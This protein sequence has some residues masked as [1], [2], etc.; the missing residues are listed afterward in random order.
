MITPSPNVSY[1]QCSEN[2]E[3]ILNKIYKSK[4]PLEL[5][6]FKNQ[7]AYGYKAIPKLSFELTSTRKETRLNA[8]TFLTKILHKPENAAQGLTYNLVDILLLIIKDD[9]V[10]EKQLALNCLLILTS[11]FIGSHT[12]ATEKNFFVLKEELKCGDA[13]IRKYIYEIF[14]GIC[15]KDKDGV[16]LF[17]SMN[18]YSLFMDKLKKECYEFQYS[19][20]N[21]LYF[22][23]Q[24]GRPSFIPTY[25]FENLSLQ[26]FSKFLDP[27]IPAK[28]KIIAEKCIMALCL[29]NEAKVESCK[30]KI[31]QKLVKLLKNR[32]KEVR[33]NAVGA[34][35]NISI[36]NDAKK[37][38]NSTNVLST[39]LD[40][41]KE[42]DQETILYTLKTITNL[43]EDYVA[44]DQL[45]DKTYL[46]E[47]FLNHSNPHIKNAAIRAIKIINWKP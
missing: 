16:N 8:L 23:I 14:H 12:I 27:Y 20:L 47:V 36:N 37:I 21:V 45:T 43:S 15:S 22:C 38:I 24:H 3:H 41:L 35:M 33:I 18:L 10:L 2:I 19:I 11:T 46:I 28:L 13:T 39:L 9:T 4:T 44:K 40:F 25:L 6:T 30:L 31:P 29:H 7:T 26:T 34:L 1:T 42:N 17:L 5:L 32:K